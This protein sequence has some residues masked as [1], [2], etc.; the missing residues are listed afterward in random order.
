MKV[1]I[2]ESADGLAVVFPASHLDIHK[3]AADLV[4]LNT[5][6]KVIDDSQLPDDSEFWGA[7]TIDCE[8]DSRKARE[9]WKDKIRIVRNA[10]LKD[11]DIEW[12]KAMENG[13][14]KVAASV[15][16]KKQMLRDVTE[17]EDFKKLKTVQQIKRYW[18][19]V[20]EG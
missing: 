16:A 1:I 19:E 12:M 18:P 14:A 4:P 2:Y 15:A 9:I 3:V 20:L 11:L 10:R 17:R 7:W 5:E 6:F 13:E 8:I